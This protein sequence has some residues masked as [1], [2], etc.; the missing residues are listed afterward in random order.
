M[1]QGGKTGGGDFI[2]AALGV[3][4]TRRRQ[5]NVSLPERTLH[6]S[7]SRHRGHFV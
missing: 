1:G 6:I 2:A 7:T 3:Y 4:Y 5:V